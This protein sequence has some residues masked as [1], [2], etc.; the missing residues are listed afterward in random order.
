M[1]GSGA[2][3]EGVAGDALDILE[4]A[5]MGVGDVEDVNVIADA[6]AVWSGIVVAKNA[7]V[8][9]IGPDGFEE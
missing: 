5:E 6:G 2:D 8:R 4:S 1:A 3:V 9:L 7:D